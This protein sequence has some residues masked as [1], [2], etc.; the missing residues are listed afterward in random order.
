MRSN[1]ADSPYRYF[2]NFIIDSFSLRR[3]SQHF[4]QLSP[5]NASSM[6][7]TTALSVAPMA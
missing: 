6:A 1:S 4:P 7:R 3:I 5:A 2:L